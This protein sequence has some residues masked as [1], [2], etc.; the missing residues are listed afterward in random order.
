MSEQRRAT[1]T[2]FGKSEKKSNKSPRKT[3]RLNFTLSDP[4]ENSCPV[5]DYA[6]TV[7]SEERKVLKKHREDKDK[8]PNGF[9]D[10]FE[11]DD[12]DVKRLARKFEAKYGD[13]KKLKSYAELGAGY[14]ET[15]PFIDNTD[16]N[17]EALQED[18]E[19]A[20]GG[21]YINSGPLELK[22]VE[23]SDQSDA[24]EVKRRGRKRSLAV[25]DE[26]E[27]EEEEEKEEEGEVEE[28]AVE[29]V[30]KSV[31][32]ELPPEP[33]KTKLLEERLEPENP[34]TPSY[35]GVDNRSPEKKKKKKKKKHREYEDENGDGSFTK[36]KKAKTVKALLEEK[37]IHEQPSRIPEEPKKQTASETSIIEAIESVVKN[38]QNPNES[39]GVHNQDENSNS[40][41]SLHSGGGSVLSTVSE[42][43]QE[44][45]APEDNS[46][47]PLP[48]CLSPEVVAL[49]NLIKQ[50]AGVTDNSRKTFCPEINNSLIKLEWKTRDVTGASRN[51]LFAHLAHHLPCT[52]ETLIRR[53]KKL[54]IQKEESHVE[55]IIC[56]L[57]ATIDAAM[58]TLQEEYG[59]E[60]QR[61]AEEKGLPASEITTPGEDNQQTSSPNAISP[62]RKFPWT[63]ETRG[64][65][66][67]IV[68]C[69]EKCYIIA[70]PRKG[71]WDDYMRAFL[72]SKIRPLWPNG[73]MKLPILIKEL[74]RLPNSAKSKHSSQ[75]ASKPDSSRPNASAGFSSSTSSNGSLY[76]S[77]SGDSHQQTV[78][79]SVAGVTP[80]AAKT[81]ADPI[82]LLSKI[83]SPYHT[84]SPA[85]KPSAGHVTEKPETFLMDSLLKRTSDAAAHDYNTTL[86]DIM[87]KEG[88]I[89]NGSS[90]PLKNVNISQKNDSRSEKILDLSSCNSSVSVSGS[91]S[92]IQSTL[93]SDRT[94]GRSS[95]SV[96]ARVNSAEKAHNYPYAS[97]GKE[98]MS[99][100]EKPQPRERDVD[101]ETTTATDML[102]QII[103]DTLRS[104]PYNPASP[105]NPAPS[106]N[107]APPP[108]KGADDKKSQGHKDQ[109]LLFDVMQDLK[110]LNHLSS[111][112]GRDNKNTSFTG[113]SWAYPVKPVDS[114]KSTPYHNEFLN[115]ISSGSGKDV[116]IAASTPTSLSYANDV[117]VAST[118]SSLSYSRHNTS[119]YD[120]SA[121]V[122]EVNKSLYSHSSHRTSQ[123]LA[124][125]TSTPTSKV[126]QVNQIKN[127]TN[128]GI[129]SG[130]P[131]RYMG[132]MDYNTEEPHLMGLASSL[133]YGLAN[134]PY[135]GNLRSTPSSNFFAKD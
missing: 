92:V 67:S 54:F 124:A 17:D 100:S 125:H 50:T 51:L 74:K 26:E 109:E 110:E 53:A 83:T 86:S 12:E 103:S 108:A 75:G 107:S 114:A 60:C 69:K 113:A 45:R 89:I 32:E 27:D 119:S 1:L 118:P 18:Q 117:S 99:A 116:S 62:K 131:H 47:P 64:Y 80:L 84:P 49:V 87:K 21:Y 11:D 39:A 2:P 13:K 36:V 38:Q 19:T 5:F 126:T 15:D 135:T 48:D 94:P 120:N 25:I 28:E 85:K 58:P 70:K 133:Q 34:Q 68:R 59:K 93:S 10:P 6:A 106:Y 7:K 57:K 41:N 71:S 40:S 42:D 52:K 31:V 127:L 35:N 55:T 4:N 22:R 46:P 72:Q 14:D 130:L 134:W 102:N 81:G 122:N 95:D 24:D 91:P 128:T 101:K 63:D 97:T 8:K 37:R 33:K 115:Y 111:G 96:G 23:V 88:V 82:N 112:G 43:S 121:Y 29:D 90:L 105:Y 65:L 104:P 79:A 129:S 56:K 30:S 77:P 16:A 73:W 3:F 76:K 98:S 132:Q 61:I 66:Q 78:K 44:G 123:S 20:C 9:L